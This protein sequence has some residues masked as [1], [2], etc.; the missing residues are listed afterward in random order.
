MA[1]VTFK[2]DICKGCGLATLSINY[3]DLGRTT[4]EMAVKILKGEADISEMPVEYFQGPV[5]KFNKDM[6]EKLNVTIPD[7]YVAIED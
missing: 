2:E 5:K 4:G 7:E 1:K 3:Y 6:A